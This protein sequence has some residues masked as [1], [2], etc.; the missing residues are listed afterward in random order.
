[1]HVCSNSA[2]QKYEDAKPRTSQRVRSSD[3]EIEAYLV[4]YGYLVSF[5]QRCQMAVFYSILVHK[6]SC[7][8]MGSYIG[9][10]KQSQNRYFRAKV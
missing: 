2:L 7:A 1:M 9:L 10:I 6:A 4:L 8:Q 3:G 5:G